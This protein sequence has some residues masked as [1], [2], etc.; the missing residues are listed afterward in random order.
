MEEKNIKDH[1]ENCECRIHGEGHGMMHKFCCGGKWHRF[2][3]IKFIVGVII[4]FGVLAVGIK[5][6]EIKTLLYIGFG[7]GTSGYYGCQTK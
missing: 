1:D 5:I 6:G 3:L 7:Y 4:L 2:F